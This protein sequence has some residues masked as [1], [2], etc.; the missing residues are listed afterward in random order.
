MKG[1]ILRMVVIQF[2]WL[3]HTSLNAQTSPAN[4]DSNNAAINN[5]LNIYHAALY[6][7]TGLYNGREYG[8]YPYRFNTGQPYFMG[9]TMMLGSVVYEGILYNNVAMK[10]NLVTNQLIITDPS[11]VHKL[12]LSNERIGSF[13][14]FNN[15]F[16]HL[17]ADSDNT[18]KPGF[19]DV[20]YDGITPVYKKIQKR[21][22]EKTTMME[23]IVR[24]VYESTSYYIKKEGRFYTVNNKKQVLKLF[25]GHKKE[26]QQYVRKQKLNIRRDKERALQLI[27]VWYDGLKK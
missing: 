18:I 26:L 14:L 6:P 19:Y 4:I 16:V 12:T 7:E 27:G 15:R 1:I 9:D 11:Y 2:F 17:D 22:D 24:T 23:G 10:F 21:I 13:K 25:A 5:A 8:D 3:T 20:I